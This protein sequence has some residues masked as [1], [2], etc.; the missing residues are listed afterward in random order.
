[1]SGLALF[2]NNMGIKV[3][4]SD[5]NN[6]AIIDK[7]I[8]NN[9]EVYVGHREENIDKNCDLVVYTGAIMDDNIE[10]ITA[11]NYGIPLME[12]SEYLGLISKRYEHIIGISGTHGKTTTTSMIALIFKNAGLNPTVHIGGICNN[13]D[14]NILIGDNK[15]FITEACEYKNS[16]RY[17]DCETA[18]IT[19]TDPDHLDSYDSVLELKR[20]YQNFALKSKNLILTKYSFDINKKGNVITVGINDKYNLVAKNISKDMNRWSFDVWNNNTYLTNFKLNAVGKYNIENALCAIAVALEY[21]ISIVTI[22]DALLQYK[23]VKRR[24]ELIASIGN[25]PIICDYAHHP[26]EIKNTIMAYK[27][28]YK[29]ILCVFQPHTYTRTVNFMG[30]F[31]KCFRG[32]NKLIVYKT[33]PAREKRIVEGDAV[34]L[35]NNIKLHD[36]VKHYVSNKYQLKRLVLENIKNVDCVLVLGAGNIYNIA[37]NVLKSQ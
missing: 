2:T 11:R 20:A 31:K 22:F 33:Y 26:T 25:I 8:R 9:I 3:T 17:L 16:F 7:L 23:G 19:S 4:G 13:F 34:T 6:D 21:D 1:M 32:V 35:Y 29:R 14:S 24:H 18:V 5:A 15:F 37:K 30:E 10:I 36:N 12:R 27:E 28:I